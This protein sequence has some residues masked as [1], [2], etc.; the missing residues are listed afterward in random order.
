VPFF[1]LLVVKRLRALGAETPAV[2]AT[3]V[4][5]LGFALQFALMMCYFWGKFDDIVIRR[6][7]LPT[8][9]GMVV[10]ILA[11]LPQ[12][13][14][15]LVMRALLGIATLGLLARSVPSMAAHAY[16]QE[17]LP[18]KETTWRRQ[19]IATQPH[20]DYLMIDNDA[21]L[22]I[23]HLVSATPTVVAVKRSVDIAFHM[24][25][26]TFSAVYVFQRFNI[27][28]DTGRMT[29]REGDDLGPAFV[30]EPVVEERLQLL[31]L[32]RI[33]RVKEIKSGNVPIST[34]DPGTHLVPK[35]RA[36]IEE[37]R[38]LY[39]DSFMKQLP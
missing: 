16:S 15:A 38:K 24:R 35:S 29:L 34:P 4:F 11:V 27:D 5:S 18:G 20:P 21:T 8:H 13:A 6:L 28:P 26:R 2:V 39:L 25:N 9:L 22:W 32:S 23:T 30:L 7:S 3:T 12:F 36:E 19:F 37:A 17:Y 33:S 1:A 14:N 10:A 31:T